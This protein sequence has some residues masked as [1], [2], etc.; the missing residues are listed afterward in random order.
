MAKIDLSSVR[1]TYIFMWCENNVD[2]DN[3]IRYIFNRSIS[4]GNINFKRLQPIIDMLGIEGIKQMIYIID[5]LDDEVNEL[6]KEWKFDDKIFTLLEVHS[7]W[8]NYNHKNQ[9]DINQRKQELAN[10]Y[11]AFVRKDD[12]I[13]TEIIKSIEQSLNINTKKKL[14][15]Y[16]VNLH[17]RINDYFKEI[18]DPYIIE[19]DTLKNELE[20]TR[21]EIKANKETLRRQNYMINLLNQKIKYMDN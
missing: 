11:N 21:N 3:S 5:K 7:E 12:I 4:W 10:E 1:Q 9:Q 20:V 19:F 14:Q 2:A 17:N 15:Y 16:L 18:Y 6:T 13:D 8:E